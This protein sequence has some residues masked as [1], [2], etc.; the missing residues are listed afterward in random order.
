MRFREAPDILERSASRA[1]SE[2]LTRRA[3]EFAREN[4]AA[5]SA[6]RR[7]QAGA[8]L[9]P[10]AQRL[11]ISI[12]HSGSRQHRHRHS[13]VRAAAGRYMEPAARPCEHWCSWQVR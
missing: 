3:I 7:D 12:T 6:A 1:G 8:L 13:G 10:L 4:P 5:F 9:E 2:R 11:G